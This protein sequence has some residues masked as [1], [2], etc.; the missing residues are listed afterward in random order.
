[1]LLALLSRSDFTLNLAL[2]KNYLTNILAL[3]SKTSKFP[4][5]RKVASSR[6]SRLVSHSRIFNCPSSSPWFRRPCAMYYV[7]H[8]WLSSLHSLLHKR[9]VSPDMC[10]IINVFLAWR[11]S[12]IGK[13]F[14]P[15]LKRQRNQFYTWAK[16]LRPFFLFFKYFL[17][18]LYCKL[19]EIITFKLYLGAW[20]KLWTKI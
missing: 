3:L 11:E 15:L 6:L 2:L 1:M 13:H 5:Y 17:Y 20:F 7:S 9:S 4:I 12:F 18:E 14:G 16:P 10:L 19:L 8:Y